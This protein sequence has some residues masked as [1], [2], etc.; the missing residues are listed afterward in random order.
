MRKRLFVLAAAAAAATAYSAAT[1]KGVFNK[2]KFKDQHDS[3]A[4]YVEGH[5]PGAVYSPVQETEHGYAVIIRRPHAAG[6][7]LYVTPTPDGH[8]VFHEASKA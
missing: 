2:M 8:Y 3:I 4:R 5:Y 6:I 1:G 7:F